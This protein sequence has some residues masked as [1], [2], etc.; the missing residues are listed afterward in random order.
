MGVLS[1]T[2]GRTYQQNLVWQQLSEGLTAVES[3]NATMES[4][5]KTMIAGS[6]AAVAAIT[7]LHMFP[8]SLITVS[9]LEAAV[10]VAMCVTVLIQ[11]W[12]AAKL[13]GP[14]PAAV[15]TTSD[16]NKLYD[17]Y[18]TVSEDVAYNNVLIDSAKRLEH[19]VWVNEQK[20]IALRSMM[21]VLQ[22]QIIVLVVGIVM[23]AFL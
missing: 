3:A 5:A 7:G 11:F 12:H 10:M 8:D 15:A 20:G 21:R 6:A 14:T 9:K 17:E 2:N 19:A 16:V 13:W 4:K 22:A 1:E 23:K 18:I